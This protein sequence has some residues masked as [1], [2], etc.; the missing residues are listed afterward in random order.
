MKILSFFP[1]RIRVGSEV[2]KN[3]T[4]VEEVKTRLSEIKGIREFEFN[5]RTGSITI[6]YD[7]S[8]ISMAMLGEAKEMLEKMEADLA[9]G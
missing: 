1:G 2:F 9:A 5:T 3:E 8:V 6:K 7:S 4:T